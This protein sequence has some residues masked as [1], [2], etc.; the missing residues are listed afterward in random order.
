MT[1][2][3]MG[4]PENVLVHLLVE[5]LVQGVGFR[6][7]VRSEANRLR[8]TGTVENLP[9]GRVEILAEGDRAVIDDFISALKRGNGY[10]RLD[11]LEKSFKAGSGN[12]DGFQIKL[13]GF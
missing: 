1:T 11:R 4:M 3:F 10:S 7:F 5:G 9:D 13:M 12:F 6:W 2:G 8:L